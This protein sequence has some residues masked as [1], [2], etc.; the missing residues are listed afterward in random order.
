MIQILWYKGLLNPSEQIIYDK[1]RNGWLK[2]Q[3]RIIFPL[4][5]F[6]LHRIQTIVSF[7]LLDTPHLFYVSIEQVSIQVMGLFAVVCVR[8]SYSSEEISSV[9]ARINTLSDGLLKRC[10]NLSPNAKWAKIHSLLIRK[11]T[12]PNDAFIT[13]HHHCIVGPLI[14]HYAVCDGFAYMVKLLCDIVEIPC[15]LVSGEAIPSGGQQSGGHVWN[16]VKISEHWM[17][18]DVTWDSLASQN[19]VATF[20]Y[21]LLTDRMIGADHIWDT[22]LV[23]PSIHVSKQE[24]AELVPCITINQLENHIEKALRNNSRGFCVR[25]Q[26]VAQAENLKQEVSSCVHR[27]TTKQCHL[28]L[29]YIFV[30]NTSTLTIFFRK[31]G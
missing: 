28:V 14:D 5:G 18:C 4:T 13:K 22:N 11:I 19:P 16:M 15:I 20:S 25:L 23:P 9:N 21:S 24:M 31:K 30:Q 10:S 17:H 29:D 7:I 26:R 1:L 8:F 6:D 12:Y 2:Q 27:V 3:S